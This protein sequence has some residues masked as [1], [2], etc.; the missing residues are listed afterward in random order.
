MGIGSNLHNAALGTA[1]R[2]G[3]KYMISDGC[4]NWN[5]MTH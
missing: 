3:K 1:S 4:V 5:G 2:M